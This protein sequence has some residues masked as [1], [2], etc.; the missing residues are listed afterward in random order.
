M[1]TVSLLASNGVRF[2]ASVALSFAPSPRSEDQ[3]T[4]SEV[5]P[6]TERVRVS[7]VSENST[8]D[9]AVVFAQVTPDGAELGSRQKTR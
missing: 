9:I 5:T 4:V 8:E 2:G 1:F 3:P 6:A 7:L